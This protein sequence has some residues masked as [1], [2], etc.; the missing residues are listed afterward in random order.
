MSAAPPDTAC[1]ARTR[2]FAVSGS[3]L[4]LDRAAG[5]LQDVSVGA[6]IGDGA[7]AS[8]SSALVVD[9]CT[10]DSGDGGAYQGS[11]SRLSVVDSS[12]TNH[13]G[14]L[15]TSA[16]VRGT[17]SALLLLRVNASGNLRGVVAAT[18]SV[19]QLF[20]SQFD[21]NSAPSGPA[22]S[23][24]RGF[25]HIA[26]STF[27]DNV[28]TAGGGG[29]ISSADTALRIER[30]VFADNTARDS[31]VNGGGALY[32]SAGSPIITA[33][34]HAT[35]T[36]N[37]AVSWSGGAIAI[38]GAVVHLADGVVFSNNTAVLGGGAISINEGQVFLDGNASFFDNS[39][40]GGGGGAIYALVSPWCNKGCGRWPH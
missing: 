40:P 24:L 19:V 12:I 33:F 36:R 1:L 7:I 34:V 21:S 9:S 23:S 8:F 39:C 3:F 30:S 26:S 22:A 27:T 10:F 18:E 15:F 20:N 11:L 5:I 13:Q 6:G 14:T 31:F 16:A 2:Q 4:Q 29:A 35:F 32:I 25:L 37:T 38:S 17:Q 28:A